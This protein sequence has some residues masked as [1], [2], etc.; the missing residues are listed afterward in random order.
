[1]SRNIPIGVLPIVAPNFQNEYRWLGSV[2]YNMSTRDQLRGRYID[3][4][5]SLIDTTANLPTF[6]QTRPLRKMLVNISEF[7]TF[8]SSI[9]NELRLA[10]NRYTD[11]VPAG[12]YKFPGLD[13]FPNIQISTALN[14]PLRPNFNAPQAKIQNTYQLPD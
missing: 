7:H 2:D 12:D 10:F 11:D 6:F 14:I 5:V 4:K 3:N 13:V 1:I 8:S 9:A